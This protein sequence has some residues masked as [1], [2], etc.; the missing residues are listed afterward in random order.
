MKRLLPFAF[1]LAVSTLLFGQASTTTRA[2]LESALGF[3][4]PVNGSMPGS[5]GAFPANAVFADEKIVHSGKYSARVE[6]DNKSENGFATVKKSLPIDFSGQTIELRG[7]LRT[8]A[9]SNF[10]GLWLREDGESG[11]VE[12]DNMQTKQIKGTTEWTEYSI[13]LPLQPD[14]RM[15]YFGA[16]VTGGGR[17]WADDLQLLVDGKP[18]WDA[19]RSKPKQTVLESDREFDGG[20]KITVTKLSP[21]Q[22]ENLVTLGKVWGFLKYHHSAIT[23]GTRHWDYELFRVLPQ[24]LAARDRQTA[25]AAM[26]Q[27]I[28]KL[29]PVGVC[30]PCAKL[31]QS[32][33]YFAPDLD[34]ISDTSR[35]GPEL[36]RAL[37]NI[38]ENRSTKKQFYIST[39]QRSR[40]P[41]LTTNWSTPTSSYRISAIKCSPFIAS[42]MP[43]SIGRPIETSSEK[44]GTPF[45]LSPSPPLRS[46]KM[47]RPTSSRFSR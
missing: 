4:A 41:P 35:L 19:P 30:S 22:V 10:A 28:E 16:L 24:V 33:L 26:M 17:I 47:L 27:W 13:V 23:S 6:S 21:T 18:I 45:W 5:W 37:R 15:L 29:G 14:A 44:I 9:V 1:I 12:F 40:S 3:E 34:W 25:N 46:P 31:D 43:S 11:I 36:S 38:Y 20:S 39:S 2:E 7:Y 8:E 42:G 32:K